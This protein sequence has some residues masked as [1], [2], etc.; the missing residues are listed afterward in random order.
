[1]EAQYKKIKQRGEG[2]RRDVLDECQTDEGVGYNPTKIG[3]SMP[4]C[5]EVNIE[6]DGIRKG[7][8]A[9]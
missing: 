3:F 4:A 1:M 2:G 7:G 8:Q 9:L 6:L 5:S